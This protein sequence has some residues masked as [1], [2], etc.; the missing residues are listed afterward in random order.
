[1]LSTLQHVGP[2]KTCPASLVQEQELVK[3][4]SYQLPF[5]NTIEDECVYSQ[6]ETK[7]TG[8]DG[9]FVFSLKNYF[10][11][12]KNSQNLEINS[13]GSV[14]RF[15]FSTK[16]VLQSTCGIHSPMSSRCCT[17]KL[18]VLYLQKMHCNFIKEANCA[19][20]KFGK[21]RKCN[22]AQ[23]SPVLILILTCNL[24]TVTT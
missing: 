23:K 4:R 16:T 12:N 17:I 3:L 13:Y 2:T 6:K 18:L 21:Q 19:V 20:G 22:W 9:F 24:T 11:W 14:F 5:N 1:M 10:S 7:N 8:A 15:T